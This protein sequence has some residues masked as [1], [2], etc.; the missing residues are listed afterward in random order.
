MGANVQQLCEN[1]ERLGNILLFPIKM[2]ENN[3]IST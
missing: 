2:P 3:A 1:D